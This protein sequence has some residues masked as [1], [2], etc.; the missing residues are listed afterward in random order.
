MWLILNPLLGRV[1]ALA[2]SVFKTKIPLKMKKKV[3]FPSV[4]STF[5]RVWCSAGLG[6]RARERENQP[7]FSALAKKIA[8]QP[9]AK[10][11]KKK[12]SSASCSSV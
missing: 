11:G 2:P 10:P 7:P 3:S 4:P 8:R 1:R 9:G 12:S 6:W 5:L